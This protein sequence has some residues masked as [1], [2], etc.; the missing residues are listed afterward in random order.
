MIENFLYITLFSYLI[1]IIIIFTISLGGYMAVYGK[2]GLEQMLSDI[3]DKTFYFET[4]IPFFIL[5]N[6]ILIIVFS[7]LYV[8]KYNIQI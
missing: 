6:I 1:F 5:H 4:V 7:Y 8:F 2:E 3:E